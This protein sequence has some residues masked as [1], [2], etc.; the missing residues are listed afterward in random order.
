MEVSFDLDVK[1]PVRFLKVEAETEETE[2]RER[3]SLQKGLE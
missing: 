2:E 1:M 3:Y